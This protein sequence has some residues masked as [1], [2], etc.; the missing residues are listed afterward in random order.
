IFCLE[1]RVGHI[2]SF[3]NLGPFYQNKT[4][5]L[6]FCETVIPLKVLNGHL[7]FSIG[8]IKCPP[9]SRSFPAIPRQVLHGN[10]RIVREGKRLFSI[11]RTDENR[12][13][14]FPKILV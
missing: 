7:E 5:Y 3:I 11:R 6:F 9:K 12:S 10:F 14:L 8:F 2:S 4:S 13:L 1:S